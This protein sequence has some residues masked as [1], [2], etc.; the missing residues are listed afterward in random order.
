MFSI[1]LR[2]KVKCTT[3]SIIV[4][5]IVPTITEVYGNVLAAQACFST[6]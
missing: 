3:V 1:L 4:L 5:N 6:F 2:R